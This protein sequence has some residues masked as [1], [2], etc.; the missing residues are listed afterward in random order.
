MPLR[1]LFRIRHLLERVGAV[2]TLLDHP[3]AISRF[4]HSGAVW[5]AGRVWGCEFVFLKLSSASS[6]S[7]ARLA[8]PVSVT[9]SLISSGSRM[10]LPRVAV[11]PLGFATVRFRVDRKSVV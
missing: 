7:R 2:F 4:F 6:L 1:A 3:R 8:P 5:R 9:L 11:L 10:W